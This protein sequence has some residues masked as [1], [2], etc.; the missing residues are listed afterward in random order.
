MR[1]AEHTLLGRVLGDGESPAWWGVPIGRLAG[2]EIRVHLVAL[3][4][5]LAVLVYSIWNGAGLPFVATGLAS[6][7]V[8]VVLHE[9]ARGHALVRWAKLRPTDI[10]L[11]P[12][13]GVWRF[14]EEEP[15]AR[16]E[17]VGAGA[18]LAMSAGVAV[19]AGVGVVML[20]GDAGR[21]LFNPIRPGLVL[22]EFEASST[23]GLV[24][25]I[26]V[27]QLYAIACGMCVVNLLPMLPL[28]GGV[29]LRFVIQDRDAFG[30]LT[31]RVGLVTA[32]VLLVGGLLTGLPLV[33]AVGLCGG[34]VCWYTWQ[35]ERFVL[36][37]AGV[38]RWRVALAAESEADETAEAEPPIPPGEREQIEAIL[39]KISASGMGSLTR[40]ERRQLQRATDRLRGS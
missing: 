16:A 2:C 7:A 22:G 28:D 10:T 24:G 30:S 40:S 36:D 33:A 31:A 34:V 3:V 37:P 26:G 5:V 18:G 32:A 13:G 21:L 25:L 8:V 38:D 1:E 4:F 6:L 39:A 35:A 19:A 17:A 11:W 14:A 15:P 23:A 27:W 12:L 20:A 9:A 29:V